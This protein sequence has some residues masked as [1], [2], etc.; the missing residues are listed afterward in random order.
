MTSF[1]VQFGT[2]AP[3]FTIEDGGEIR[4][5]PTAGLEF[6]SSSVSGDVSC[7]MGIATGGVKES[8][9]DILSAP[10]SG[11]V[12]TWTGD[13]MDWVAPSGGGGGMTSFTSTVNG[14][15]NIAIGDGDYFD[16]GVGASRGVVLEGTNHPGGGVRID[17]SIPYEAITEDHLDISGEPESGQLL[18]WNGAMMY[19]DDPTNIFSP[20]TGYGISNTSNPFISITPGCVRD[21]VIILEPENNIEFKAA[22][23]MSE[24][25]SYEYIYYI[26]ARQK[27]IDI[28]LPSDLLW[29]Y[30]RKDDLTNLS[31]GTTVVIRIRNINKSH[32]IVSASKQIP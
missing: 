30:E 21:S 16:L 23:D 31:P 32:C 8:Y 25:R 26:T 17:I 15:G 11:D 7:N 13:E 18:K 24:D 3:T 4:F 19:W 12:L 27:V 6:V 5:N 20:V 10:A 1:D 29:F 14:T 22:L 9:L 28:D 2:T